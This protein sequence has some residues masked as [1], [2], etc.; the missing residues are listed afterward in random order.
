MDVGNG[1]HIYGTRF[2]GKDGRGCTGK[3]VAHPAHDVHSM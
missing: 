2:A 3:G 1:E